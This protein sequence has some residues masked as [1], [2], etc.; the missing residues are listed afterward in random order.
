MT[1]AWAI[2]G[3][4][5]LSSTFFYRLLRERGLIAIERLMGML[6]VMVV[7]ADAGKWAENACY[8]P[9]RSRLAVRQGLPVKYPRNDH[10]PP[11]S[12]SSAG[13]ACRD[14]RRCA[15]SAAVAGQIDARLHRHAYERQ[16]QGHLSVPP[17]VGRHRSLSERHACAA[18]ARRRDGES[19]IL[20]DRCAA[21]AA[22]RRQRGRSVRGQAGRR[23]QRVCD[24]RYG[25]AE[26]AQ[27]ARLDGHGAVP[28]R[29][30]RRRQTLLVANCGDGTVAVLPVA[31]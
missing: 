7:G 11:G 31:G 15:G 17:A 23:G 24:R 12:G 28:S 6:L 30:R 19:N 3:A 14:C 2:G 9:A 1:I 20:R 5:L 10:S 22:V 29:H 18:R 26:A 25:Q 13:R 27:S 16:G 21:P 8:G 4:I